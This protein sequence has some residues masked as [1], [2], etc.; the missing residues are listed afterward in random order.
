LEVIGYL[1]LHLSEVCG[2]ILIAFLK[3]LLGEL[4]NFS[5]HHAFLV[6]EKAVR[7]TEEA[8][9]RHYFLEETELGI[10]LLLILALDSLLNGGVDLRVDLGC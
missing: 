1:G 4:S 7:T 6:L 9:E 3:S 5:G 2:N 10:S 8:I